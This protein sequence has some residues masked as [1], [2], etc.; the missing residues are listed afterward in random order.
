VSG[1]GL[2]PRGADLLGW[3]N[4]ETGT[5]QRS[6]WGWGVAWKLMLGISLLV[7]LSSTLGQIL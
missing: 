4:L 3:S 6:C 2:S 5:R 1:A 7:K